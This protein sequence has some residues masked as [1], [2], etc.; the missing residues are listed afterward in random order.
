[1][2]SLLD[3]YLYLELLLALGEEFRVRGLNFYQ[4]ISVT[5][6]IDNKL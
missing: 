2:G 3:Y 5:G 6:W 1:M 4:S